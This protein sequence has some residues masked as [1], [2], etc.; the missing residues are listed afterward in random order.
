MLKKYIIGDTTYHIVGSGSEKY[1]V[2]TGYAHIEKP[3][4][5]GLFTRYKKVIERITYVPIN[6]LTMMLFFKLMSLNPKTADDTDDVQMYEVITKEMNIEFNKDVKDRLS[7]LDLSDNDYLAFDVRLNPNNEVVKGFVKEGWN[8]L[9]AERLNSMHRKHY[10]Y[11]I[12][13]YGG[14]LQFTI[15]NEIGFEN[16]DKITAELSSCVLPREFIGEL[17]NLLVNKAVEIDKNKKEN[18]E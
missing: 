4:L 15:L 10:L 18:G 3:K 5:L 1:I 6:P 9:G 2:E 7:K 13:L 8:Y 17:T 11:R 16:S 12:T 14:H